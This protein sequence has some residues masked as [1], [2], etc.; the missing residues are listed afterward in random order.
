MVLFLSL[1]SKPLYIKR[2]RNIEPFSNRERSK[3]IIQL[4]NKIQ[5]LEIAFLRT[6]SAAFLTAMSTFRTSMSIYLITSSTAYCI[7]H[8]VPFDFFSAHF[9]HNNF[10]FFKLC[11]LFHCKS[12]LLKRTAFS[13]NVFSESSHIHACVLK[14]HFH[15]GTQV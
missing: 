2:F 15:V 3:L 8:Q 5:L 14:V 6:I 7:F 10:N 13:S 4:L 1:Y 9:A 12:S 11:N